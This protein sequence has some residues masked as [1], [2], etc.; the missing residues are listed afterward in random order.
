M[1]VLIVDSCRD[2]TAGFEK[3]FQHNGDDVRV[4]H[5]GHEAIEIAK[6]FC[7]ELVIT[8]TQL[9]GVDG[10]ELARTVKSHCGADARILAVSAAFDGRCTN[11]DN[12]ID[13]Y[14]LKPV[15]FERLL[16][17]AKV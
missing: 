14:F 9:P 11:A 2:T 10:Y 5:S 12:P 7:P 15:S 16:A 17:A 4:A 3:L 6:Q 8:E 1:R 13:S